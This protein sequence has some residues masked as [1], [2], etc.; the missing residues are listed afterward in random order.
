MKENQSFRKAAAI[1]Y[2]MEKDRAPKVMASGQG[3]IAEKIIELAREAGIPL[4][5]DPALAEI[6]SKIDPGESIPPE[7][8]RAV[9]EILV[10]IYKLDNDKALERF[11]KK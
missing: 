5:E 11:G 6:L 2:D 1:S 9:A 10:F 7:T 3:L 4:Q 8:Y